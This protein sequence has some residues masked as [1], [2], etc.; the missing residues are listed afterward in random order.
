MP[1]LSIDPALTAT[2]YR[3]DEDQIAYACSDCG[4]S[5]WMSY[6]LD[7][8]PTYCDRC[9]DARCDQWQQNMDWYAARREVRP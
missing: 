4:A 5:F 6:P 8:G 9:E 3:I 7:E 1:K 2:D